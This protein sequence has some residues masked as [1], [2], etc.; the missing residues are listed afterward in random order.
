MKESQETGRNVFVL[1]CARARW[2][3]MHM[4]YIVCIL[5]GEAALM[6]SPFF[7]AQIHGGVLMTE[8]QCR[9]NIG[10]ESGGSLHGLDF[11]EFP[12]TSYEE[13]KEAAVA[14][15]K[16][17]PFEKSMYTKTYE[18]ITLEPLYTMDHVREISAARTFPAENLMLRGVSASGYVACPWEIAQAC[19]TFEP[20][21]ANEVARN[22]LEKGSSSVLFR[23]DSSV[24]AG[25][26][27]DE[28]DT[29]RL[30]G[31]SLSTLEDAEI[32]LEGIDADK[33]PIHAYCGAS[34]A[35]MLG[36]AA[37][38]LSKKGF[39]QESLHGCLGADPIGFYAENGRTF[40]D[41]GQLYDEIAHTIYY[42]GKNMPNLRTVL[43]RGSI[44]HNAGANAIQ[45][46]GCAMVN[47]IELINEMAV[48]SID[49]DAF[50]RHMRF[51][52]SIGANFFMEIAKIRAARVVWARIAEL[53]G[54]AQA[55]QKVNIFGRT[56]FFTKTIYDPYVNMLRN[57]AEAFAGVVGGVDGMTVGCFDEAIRTSDPFSRRVARNS[58]IMLQEEFHLTQ[59]VD[60]AGGSWYLESLTDALAH[61]IWAYIREIEAN[62]GIL[63]CLRSGRIQ[64]EIDKV[65]QDRF[66]KLASRADRAVGTN[67]YANTTEE[68][69]KAEPADISAM[70]RVRGE[71]ISKYCQARSWVDVDI[72]L[73]PIAE[74]NFEGGRLINAII[75][76]VSAGAT[77]G[78]LREVLNDDDRGEAEITPLPLHR[79]TEQY[80]E[81]R[82]R[83]EKYR[84]ETG[85][86]VKVFLSNMGPIPQHKARA[87]F[88]TG[89]MEV[90]KFE[91]IKNDGYPTVEECAEATVQS[92]AD[93]SVICS[94]D[95]TYP[96]LVPRLTRLIKD[97]KPEMRVLLAGAPAEE[98][99]QSYVDAGV[100]DF[101]SVRSNCLSILTELQKTKGMF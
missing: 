51:E 4:I 73:K 71:S 10:E 34:S 63:E 49:V 74:N 9:G 90:A 61:K 19:E 97:K 39:R 54:G 40:C 16:G 31:V 20:E 95:V 70:K 80:E 65:L 60:P 82:K 22:E 2:V 66:K 33:Y 83:T 57:T 13:W 101:I 15:L 17:A 43:I 92:G 89:F 93:I 56:S 44:Y 26:D 79:W 84:N 77:L 14:A 87:D 100:D 23:F 85:D 50:A 53:Y 29:C 1:D 30:D 27:A 45:E 78:Q 55:S 72:S 37:A 64:S 99:R 6:V 38:A 96:E 81:M 7:Y 42:A 98:Y 41:I 88:I 12:P 47:A 11:S 69:L 67:M 36:F 46:V 48:R 94:T 52:F 5:D 21:T 58:Q 3:Q 62:G 59:P 25:Q 91:V 18:G 75:G 8:E 35:P 76:A 28:T 32:L 24:L 68:P 86:S